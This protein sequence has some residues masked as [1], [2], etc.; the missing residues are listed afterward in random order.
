M[1]RVRVIVPAAGEGKRF[2]S[3]EK[4]TF[5]SIKGIPLIIHT[6]RRLEADPLVDSI[7]PVIREEDIKRFNEMIR[8][9]GLKKTREAIAG[10]IE[11]QDSVYNGLRFFLE[12]IND[13][14]ALIM[15]HDGARPLIPEGLIA[16]MV[17]ELMDDPE[18]DG[19]IPGIRLTDTIKETDNKG[20]VKRTLDRESLIAVQTPQLFKLGVLER[21]YKRAYEQGIYATDDSC[22]VEQIGGRVKVIEGSIRNLKITRKEDINLLYLYIGEVYDQDWDWL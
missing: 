14:E 3:S 22:L 7:L 5:F 19:I 4:K 1:K 10:G 18:I 21:A 8:T 20:L 11:R 6:L 2:G 16:N 17:R 15:I 12:D 9:Y 13:P